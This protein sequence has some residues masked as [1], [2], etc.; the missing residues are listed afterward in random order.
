MRVAAAGWAGARLLGWHGP[1]VAGWLGWRRWWLLAGLAR[2]VAAGW[3][4]AGGGGWLSWRGR[5]LLAGFVR[6]ATRQAAALVFCYLFAVCLLYVFV[7]MCTL[8]LFLDARLA[9]PV[10]LADP[11]QLVDS[12]LFYIC[13]VRIFRRFVSFC[14]EFSICG[15][16]PCHRVVTSGHS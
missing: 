1:M 10:G 14:T 3:A 2:T 11:G 5:W 13:L 7:S 12:F 6:S 9:A 16:P 4:C 8:C 15:S